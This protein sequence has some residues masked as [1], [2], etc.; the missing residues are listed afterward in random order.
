MNGAGY[1]FDHQE[2][3]SARYKCTLKSRP[4]NKGVWTS[5]YMALLHLSDI[6]RERTRSARVDERTDSPPDAD[7]TALIEALLG[8][9]PGA[10]SGLG[11][12]GAM[13]IAAGRGVATKL[14]L[15]VAPL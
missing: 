4:P 6:G 11:V 13:G 12:K 10:S 9:D 15:F 1:L 8:E 2:P 7:E 14:S 5:G 3:D